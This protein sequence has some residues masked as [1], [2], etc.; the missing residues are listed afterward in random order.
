MAETRTVVLDIEIKRLPE[1]VGGWGQLEKMGCSVAVTCE[2]DKN[3]RTYEHRTSNIEHPTPNIGTF[4]LWTDVELSEEERMRLL[5]AFKII[6]PLDAL[7]DWIRGAAVVGWNH[8]AFDYSVLKGEGVECRA[9]RDIDLCAIIGG[10]LEDAARLN[11]GRGKGMNSAALPRMWRQG[12]IVEVALEC[13][14]HVELTRDLYL[15]ALRTG[16][17]L[18]AGGMRHAACGTLNERTRTASNPFNA[19][20]KRAAGNRKL[21]RR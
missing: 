12:K 3:R 18:T 15:L 21:W 6:S 14:R 17:V 16:R 19:R 4:R 8:V 10:R 9:A 13:R 7:A 11:L 20:T 2:L 5:F 1:E